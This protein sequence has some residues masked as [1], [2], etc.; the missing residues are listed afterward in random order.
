MIR[1][2]HNHKLQTTAWEWEIYYFKIKIIPFII[3]L[4]RNYA[5]CYWQVQVKKRSL[6]KSSKYLE[7]EIKA[8]IMSV[9]LLLETTWSLSH[10]KTNLQQE[11]H[12]LYSSEYLQF[13]YI[14]SS[15]ILQIYC[16]KDNGEQ[17]TFSDMTTIYIVSVVEK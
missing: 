9:W 7:V 15:Q 16:P 10:N 5:I 12:N 17:H 6:S 13:I 8:S 4:R 1:K 3:N 11:E 2:Y 14:I